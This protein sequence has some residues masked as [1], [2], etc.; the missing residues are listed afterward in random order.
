LDTLLP[1]EVQQATIGLRV[2]YAH[3]RDALDTLLAKRLPDVDIITAGGPGVPALAA[4]YPRSRGPELVT[5][6]PDY[7]KHPRDEAERQLVDLVAP[8]KA[9]VVVWEEGNPQAGNLLALARAKGISSPRPGGRG[10]GEGRSR[11]GGGTGGAGYGVRLV[12][13]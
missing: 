9:A 13:P 6:T 12:S 5:V 8:A 4:S 7:R 10:S 11:R 1:A 2:D 3:L